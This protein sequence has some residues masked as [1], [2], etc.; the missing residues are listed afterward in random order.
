M[1]KQTQELKV[2]I[3]LTEYKQYSAGATDVN[4]ETWKDLLDKSTITKPTKIWGFKVTKGGTWVGS[5]KIR[6]TDG[7]GNKIWP[8]MDELVDNVGFFSAVQHYL[9]SA[10]EVP[11][12]SGYKLQFRSSSTGDGSGETL[13]LNSL[14]VIETG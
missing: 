8:Y 6:I 3:T 7:S 13:E 10:V 5:A 11:V 14:D 1:T 12:S 2:G 4:G 9:H